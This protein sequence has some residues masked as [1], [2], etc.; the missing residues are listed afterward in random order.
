MATTPTERP[1]RTVYDCIQ[2]AL[3]CL[4]DVAVSQLPGGVD[5]VI[6]IYEN[7]IKVLMRCDPPARVD[8]P[9]KVDNAIVQLEEIAHQ[10]ERHRHR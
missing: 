9:K 10:Y 3:D 8:V 6:A 4:Q 7:R 2:R 5:D 1:R